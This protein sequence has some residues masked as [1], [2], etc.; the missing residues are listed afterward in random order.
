MEIALDSLIR[1]RM[2]ALAV[3]HGVVAFALGFF[4]IIAMTEASWVVGLIAL[5]AL[6][7]I[8]WSYLVKRRRVLR[9]RATVIVFHDS[10]MEIQRQGETPQ[11]ARW[12]D[13]QHIRH[14]YL[15][16]SAGVFDP[17]VWRPHDEIHTTQNTVVSVPW[18]PALSK[19]LL[20]HARPHIPDR[21]Y[22]G[23][24]LAH[25]K[26]LRDR[27][28]Q[29]GFV[30]WVLAVL[31]VWTLLNTNVA[32]VNAPEVEYRWFTSRPGHAGLPVI[33]AGWAAI[34]LTANLLN[35][36]HYGLQRRRIGTKIPKG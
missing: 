35:W 7:P 14:P 9:D 22:R 16:G 17:D 8:G 23:W 15:T 30:A 26:Y 5:A 6:L 18:F 19:M 27:L 25:D 36:I 2:A 29:F 33:L 21:A 4:A 10:G 11:H 12:D 28:I 3:H 31:I 24:R 20:A 1:R 13:I 32:P 34:C